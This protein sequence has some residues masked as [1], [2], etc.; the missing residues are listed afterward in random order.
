M[1]ALPPLPESLIVGRVAGLQA[2]RDRLAAGDAFL[3]PALAAL[4][5]R[6]E[7]ALAVGPF[8]VVD[9]PAVPPSGDRHDYLS[10]GPYW[11]P[12]PAKPDG[13]PYI[14]RDGE[15]NPERNQGDSI[16]M[17][18]MTKAVGDLS[19]AYWFT[20]DERYAAWAARLLQAWFLDPATRMNPH[21]E[22][23]QAIPGR[24]PGRGIGIIDTTGFVELVDR[25]LLLRTSAHWSAADH[26]GL[27]AWFA[28][29]L[30]WLLTS[31]HGREERAAHN[32]HGTWFDAQAA[33]FARFVGRE[34]VVAEILAT[35]GE[36][37]V[38][39]Q[40]EP[41]G[42]Q[43]HELARTKSWSYSIYNLQALQVLARLGEEAG[44]DL[45]HYRTADGRSVRGPLDFLAGYLDGTNPWPWQQ[46]GGWQ[47]ATLLGTL[48]TAAW[49]TGSDEYAAAALALPVEATGADPLWLRFPLSAP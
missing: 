32:N 34:P 42:R 12:D 17:G 8:S 10:V 5:E 14:R 39:R 18:R 29:Y 31:N 49:G 37:R 47:P 9:D 6:A 35:V 33:A 36:Q 16:A 27:Q 22:Y 44:V 11:W 23:G 38:A 3:A 19:L 15:V 2:A 26:V 45:W 40:V 25:V 4:R 20:G 30:D 43:P 24:C 7:Q 28:D 21:L 48:L 46:L 13:L 1:T 41:D